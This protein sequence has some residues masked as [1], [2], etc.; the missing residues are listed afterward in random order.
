MT[1]PFRLSALKKLYSSLFAFKI[2]AQRSEPF[3]HPPDRAG[4]ERPSTAFYYYN[5]T[6]QMYDYRSHL[7]EPEG[8]KFKAGR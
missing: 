2:K 6:V 7:V 1:V 8:I 5:P 4:L 3:V